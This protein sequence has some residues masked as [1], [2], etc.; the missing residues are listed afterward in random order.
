[1]Q[2]RAL[3]EHQ[4]SNRTV[5]VMVIL[6]ALSVLLSAALDPKV[7]TGWLWLSLWCWVDIGSARVEASEREKKELL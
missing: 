1:M 3:F 4:M 6:A 2:A 5:G 7:P